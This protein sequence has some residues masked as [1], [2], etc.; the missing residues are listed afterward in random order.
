LFKF[1]HSIN[2]NEQHS[3]LLQHKGDPEMALTQLVHSVQTEREKVGSIGSAVPRFDSR[4]SRIKGFS[5]RTEHTREGLHSL[6]ARIAEVE[7]QH[8][9]STRTTVRAFVRQEL[10]EGLRR[11]PELP[12]SMEAVVSADNA[13]PGYSMVYFGRNR[14][15]R[16]PNLEVFSAELESVSLVSQSSAVDRNAAIQRTAEAGYT[17]SRLQAPS[18][19]DI[20]QVLRLYREAYQLYTF[21]IN[22]V[23]VR[24][25]LNN[26]NIVLVG[27][28]EK[29][30]I[31][32][33]LIAE[34]CTLEIESRG[35]VH[36]Y[37][38]SDYATF[39]SHR[40]NGLITAMQIEIAEILRS[41]PGGE[42][43]IVYSEDRAAWRAVNISSVKAGMRYCGT[44]PLHC[45]L[46]SDRDFD[47]GGEYE[48][49][50]VFSVPPNVI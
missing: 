6:F 26:G 11:E 28:D 35:P 30:N 43:A 2:I 20:A 23:T 49:L 19:N 3:T 24:D 31:V 7:K 18:A 4:N 37:E 1:K 39:R 42:R 38:L 41:M 12:Y 16:L 17:I 8:P 13:L 27:R 5:P 10:V 29:G 47:Q 15:Q 14:E 33:S 25:V 22:E 36:I 34:H 44:L 21:E 40:G 50:N 48:S 9:Q 32:S 45:L 46:V